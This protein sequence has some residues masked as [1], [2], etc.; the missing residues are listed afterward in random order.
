MMENKES[1][2]SENKI[3]AS[4]SMKYDHRYSVLY[5]KS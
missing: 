2:A 5:Y 3:S 4:M 1:C